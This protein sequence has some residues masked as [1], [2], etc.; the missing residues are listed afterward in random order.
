M[1]ASTSAAKPAVPGSLEEKIREKYKDDMANVEDVEELIL[2]TITKMDR[3]SDSDRAFLEKFTGLSYLSL[4][5][6]GLTTVANMP[7]LPSL[8]Y[9]SPLGFIPGSWN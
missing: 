4:N 8:A 9:V 2:D 5:M 1:A 6:L 7:K 3:F